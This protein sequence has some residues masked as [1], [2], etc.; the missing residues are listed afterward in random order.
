LGFCVFT[1]RPAHA[2]ENS[3]GRLFML[4]LELGHA[5]A[6]TPERPGPV[7]TAHAALLPGFMFGYPG[8][9]AGRFAISAVGQFDYRNPDWDVGVG[10]RLSGLLV[11]ALNFVPIKVAAEATYL[12]RDRGARLAGGPM[13]GLGRL[14][15][16]SLFYGYETDRKTHFAYVGMGVDLAALCDLMGAVTWYVPQGDGGFGVK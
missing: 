13:F 16:L 11:P 2:D 10:G 3:A 12:V 8:T 15:Q 5:A 14:L 6:W 1:T 7:Y 4:P 9:F